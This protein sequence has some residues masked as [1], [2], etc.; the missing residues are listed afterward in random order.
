[1]SLADQIF[2]SLAAVNLQDAARLRPLT[3]SEKSTLEQCEAKGGK[4][5][6]EIQHSIKQV[7]EG[8]DPWKA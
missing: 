3:Q 7:K 5:L 2:N 1:M 6:A 8:G 4:L